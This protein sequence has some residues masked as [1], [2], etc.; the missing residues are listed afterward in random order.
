MRMVST[1]VCFLLV[2]EAFSIR[3]IRRLID[4]ITYLRRGYVLKLC[5]A[6]DVMRGLDATQNNRVKGYIGILSTDRDK[7]LFDKNVLNVL[8]KFILKDFD[9]QGTLDYLNKLGYARSYYD[10]A[11]MEVQLDNFAGVNHPNFSWNKNFK[12]AKDLLIDEVRRWDLKEIRYTGNDDCIKCI[13][14]KKAHAGF[15]FILTGRRTK[16]LYF[17]DIYSTYVNELREALSNG[18]FNKPILCMS[19]TAGTTPFDNKGERTGSFQSK[20]RVVSAIDIFQIL[21]ECTFARPFQWAMSKTSWYAGGKDDPEIGSRL[22][23]MINN[24]GYSLTVDYS[25][26]DQHISDWL[27]REAFDVVRAAFNPEWFSEDVFRVIREDFIHK[28]FIDGEGK[29]VES[30]K[31]VP[32]GSMFTQIIDS[33]VN[34][35]MVDTYFI[36]K[37]TKEWEMMI[38]GDDNIIFT[39]ESLTAESIGG[40]IRQNFGVKVSETPGKISSAE[41]GKSDPEFLS[42]TWTAMGVWREKHELFARILFPERW[43]EYKSTNLHPAQVVQ[44]YILTFPLGM[45]E[46]IDVKAFKAYYDTEISRMSS[47]QLSEWMSGLMRFRAEYLNK[48]TLRLPSV[49]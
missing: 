14:K 48:D 15:S 30:H 7:A 23:S 8:A 37:G 34:R 39:R 12:R 18:S 36:A 20:P 44:A 26:F 5:K 28:V 46:L 49:A 33:V 43:R 6:E 31:G 24:Y 45:A 27:I 47:G 25:K 4:H 22:L 41:R 35:L 38:M 17:E 1:N 2:V 9:F 32:S 40:Y 11:A 29:L 21:A 3:S 16:E 13:P 19:R 42:R 10:Y